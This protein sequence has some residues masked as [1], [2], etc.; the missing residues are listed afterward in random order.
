MAKLTK[1]NN[2]YVIDNP[3]LST[4]NEMELDNGEILYQTTLLF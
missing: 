1:R 3:N 2:V 4:I